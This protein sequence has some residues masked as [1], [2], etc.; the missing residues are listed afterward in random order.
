MQRYKVI[1]ASG[2]TVNMRTSASTT[3]NVI[4]K[5][6][7]G[8]EVEAEPCQEGWHRVTYM[9]ITGYMM[10]KFL[11]PV[12]SEPSDMDKL[13][14]RVNMLEARVAAIEGGAAQ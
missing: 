6:H 11:E 1:A 8:Q 14:S 5:V 2:E 9:H 7:V 12:A 10:S 3:A 4:V 13:I